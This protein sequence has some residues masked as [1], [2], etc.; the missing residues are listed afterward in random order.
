MLL[1]NFSIIACVLILGLST[2]NAQDYTAIKITPT[3]SVNSL[4]KHT[5]VI[6][7]DPFYKGSARLEFYNNASQVTASAYNN[8]ESRYIQELLSEQINANTDSILAEYFTKMLY[9]R[10]MDIHNPTTFFKV[11]SAKKLC[12]KYIYMDLVKTSKHST[13]PFDSIPQTYYTSTYERWMWMDSMLYC[14]STF[15]FGSSHTNQKKSRR[16]IHQDFNKLVRSI[17]LHKKEP[18]E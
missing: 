9:Q 1:D 14:F 2:M 11:K 13:A 12:K 15:S 10:V 3:L 7:D 17:C 6:D 16:V 18:E 5:L 4:E 8:T